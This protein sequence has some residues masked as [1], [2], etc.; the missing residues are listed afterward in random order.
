MLPDIKSKSRRCCS[1]SQAWAWAVAVCEMAVDYGDPD[2]AVMLAS[3]LEHWLEARRLY[4]VS[5]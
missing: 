5:A 4:G 2:A 3:C 1:P